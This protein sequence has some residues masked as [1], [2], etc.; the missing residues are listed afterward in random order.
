[1]TTPNINA[2]Q[3]AINPATGSLYYVD[4]NS[5][6]VETSLDWIKETTQITTSEDVLLSNDLTISGNLTVNGNTVVVNTET[7]TVEDNIII[8]LF[9]CIHFGKSKCD[10]SVES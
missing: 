6:I 10:Q 2:N 8:V 5:N 1:M 3:I 9:D 7:I 4:E